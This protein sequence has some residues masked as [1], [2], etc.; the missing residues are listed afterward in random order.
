MSTILGRGWGVGP[1]VVLHLDFNNFLNELLGICN[2]NLFL[3]HMVSLENYSCLCPVYGTV[4][5]PTHVQLK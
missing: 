2:V 3:G 5:Q 1:F 4:T